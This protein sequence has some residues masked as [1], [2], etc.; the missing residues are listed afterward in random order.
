MEKFRKKKFDQKNGKTAQF[1]VKPHEYSL[2]IIQTFTP[3][4]PYAL[5]LMHSG[6]HLNLVP[7]DPTRPNFFNFYSQNFFSYFHPIFFLFSLNSPLEMHSFLQNNQHFQ[8]IILILIHF[9]II[10]FLILHTI[11][12]RFWV[13]FLRM[14]MM[15]VYR[16]FFAIYL[17]HKKGKLKDEDEFEVV[18][19]K[20]AMEVNSKEN[21]FGNFWS[22]STNYPLF[23]KITSNIFHRFFWILNQKIEF[24]QI[25]KIV[26]LSERHS[27]VAY[28]HL[29]NSY[30]LSLQ[31][32]SKIKFAKL[33]R[34]LISIKNWDIT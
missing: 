9:I 10:R 6:K 13:V 29:M 18:N 2:R 23:G 20:L 11:F 28:P 32:F 26:S 21:S 3:C 15:I 27:S 30:L 8:I 1:F 16:F 5:I 14:K 22:F 25:L 7:F 31:F 34:N 33:E 17:F 12:S 4:H 19:P 24:N